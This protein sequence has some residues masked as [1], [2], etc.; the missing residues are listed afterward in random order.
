MYNTILA[1]GLLFI[2]TVHA[3]FDLERSL[4]PLILIGIGYLII[5]DRVD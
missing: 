1:L 2:A 3:A 4:E 5:K